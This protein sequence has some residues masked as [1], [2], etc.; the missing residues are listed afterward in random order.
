LHYGL[1]ITRQVRERSPKTAVIVLSRYVQ[2][3]L[4]QAPLG[5]QRKLELLRILR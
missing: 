1:E 3:W 4:L 2:S 5:A